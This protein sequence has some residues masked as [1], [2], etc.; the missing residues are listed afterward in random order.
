MSLPVL[1][2]ILG[3][4]EAHPDQELGRRL[5][6]LL[7]SIERPKIAHPSKF[8]IGREVQKAVA[9]LLLTVPFE[10]KGEFAVVWAQNREP[11]G[12]MLFAESQWPAVD[13]DLWAY[14]RTKYR[15]HNIS[16]LT[17]AEGIRQLAL[18]GK[19]IVLTAEI[20]IENERTRVGAVRWLKVLGFIASKKNEESTYKRI[21][22]AA[23]TKELLHKAL[24]SLPEQYQKPEKKMPPLPPDLLTKFMTP[25]T[26]SFDEG[27]KALLDRR[28]A[29]P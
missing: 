19:D 6:K 22:M 28:R 13:Y 24:L 20:L 5:E 2:K 10:E 23:Y 18:Q 17:L 9:P 21:F 27:G 25:L 7:R 4:R 11:Y 29:A 26:S 14:T 8:W 15:G 3:R 16:K 1:E 12:L